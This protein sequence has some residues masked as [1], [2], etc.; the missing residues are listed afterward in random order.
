VAILAMS[1]LR[2]PKA[3]GIRRRA[4][5]RA[6]LYGVLFA[7][8]GQLGYG[9]YCEA[10]PKRK[11][12][13]YG[14]KFSKIVA[15][16]ADRPLVA[17]FGSSRTLLGFNAGL[18]EAENPQWHAFNF[19]SP[20][21]GPITHLV[22]LKRMLRGGV[23]PDLLLLEVLPA[24]L[25]DGPD[26]PGEQLFFTGERLSL[27]EVELVE[28]YGFRSEPV[29]A[30]WRD[31]L[32]CPMSALRFQIVGR[33]APSFLPW[34]L[35]S[36]WSRNTDANG[37]TTPI[38]QTVTPQE[39]AERTAYAGNEYRATLASMAIEGRPLLAVKEIL[40]ICRDRGIPC[41]VVVMPEA[42]T[43]QALYPPGL[44]DRIVETFAAIAKENGSGIID[45][46]NWMTEDDLYDGHH[47]L[48]AGAGKF[49]RRLTD[50][51]IRPYIG[52]G[53]SR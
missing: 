35:R 21:S 28:G 40:A 47:P 9:A 51:A 53:G 30:A 14:D 44:S 33:Y 24:A 16:P 41:R 5:P 18:V 22:Y 34:Q 31:T 10:N 6:V 38:R 4:A 2:S 25:A 7:V 29:R 23:V 46:R 52:A 45:A 48:R 36:D 32:Y 3:Y 15:R 27:E 26:G 17:M 42:P 43:F 37:W 49:T 12:P 19:G 39:R 8:L 20:A 11:D 50:E 13:T 1:R